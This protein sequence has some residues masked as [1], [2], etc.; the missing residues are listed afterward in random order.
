MF[1]IN[2]K[3]QQWLAAS[4]RA[5]QFG[6]GCFTTARIL[7]G[8][9]QFLDLHLQRLRL[10]CERLLIPFQDWETLAQEMAQLAHGKADGV[11]KAILSRGAGGRG[12]GSAGCESPTRML[13]V[14]PAPAHYARWREQGVTLALSEVRLGRNPRLAGIKHLNRLEQVLIRA[15]LE[16]TTADEALVL[17]SDGWLVECCAANLF[18]RKGDEVFTPRV[19]NAGVNGIMRQYCLRQLATSAFR[20]VEVNAR[21]QALAQADE[22][23]ICNALMPVVPVREW[24]ELRWS[25][26]DLYH[27]L[28][29]L[30]ERIHPL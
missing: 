2:G 16:E 7:D 10:A 14:S 30:C 15:G 9:I 1:L 27:F 8:Q 29:P 6:D 20:V 11:V 13:S 17:D 26:R 4:D 25:A 21:P 24:A 19:D 3:E 22:V 28:A 18:W 23:M 12:Y 5:T